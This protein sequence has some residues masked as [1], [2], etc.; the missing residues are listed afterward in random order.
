[1]RFTFSVHNFVT[2]LLVCYDESS[3]IPLKMFFIIEACV[4]LTPPLHTF[5][6]LCS[7]VNCGYEM[8]VHLLGMVY[9]V[10][11]GSPQRAY[12]SICMV[13]LAHLCM[14]RSLQMYWIVQVHCI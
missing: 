10:V 1:M 3:A 4:V 2:C 14:S 5:A 8:K 6:Y 7:R 13:K 12:M 11:R 9:F